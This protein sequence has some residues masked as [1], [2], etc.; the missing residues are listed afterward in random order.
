MN[1]EAYLQH[2]LTYTHT[3]TQTQSYIQNQFISN[4]HIY[5]GTSGWF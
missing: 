1:F 3:R 2:K 5:V 4:I